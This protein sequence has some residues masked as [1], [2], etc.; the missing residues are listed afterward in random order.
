[1]WSLRCA[2]VVLLCVLLIL[3]L[4]SIPFHRFQDVEDRIIRT[5]PTPIDRWALGEAR[6]TID[7]SKKKKPVL[8]VDR[9]HTLLQK[10]CKSGFREGGKGMQQHVGF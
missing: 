9:V 2:I 10:V 6:E 4:I 3:I 1:M 5:F 8:P 7:K